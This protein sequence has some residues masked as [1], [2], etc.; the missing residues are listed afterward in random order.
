MLKRSVRTSCGAKLKSIV[1]GCGFCLGLLGLP[2]IADGELSIGQEVIDHKIF[3][4]DKI[5]VDASPEAVWAILTDYEDAPKVY[6][7]VSQCHVIT[8]D[9]P[10]KIVEF[11][12]KVF[13]MTI[14][15]TL[16]VQEHYPTSIEWSRNSGAFKANEGYWR[17]DPADGGR[18]CIVTYAKFIDA[19]SM[20]YFVNKELKT[21]MPVI[22]NSVKTSAERYE[23]RMIRANATH[24]TDL[25]VHNVSGRNPFFRQ[26]ILEAPESFSLA[27]SNAIL[28]R[29]PVEEV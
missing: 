1:I 22:L 27:A 26:N 9:G 19:G 15:Y 21:D 20:Q 3:Q 12:V 11:K 2:A 8:N 25:R 10:K 5:K 6:S 13:L 24:R 29:P 16:N 18:N 23:Q 17:L 7:K 14:G 4:V 28:D